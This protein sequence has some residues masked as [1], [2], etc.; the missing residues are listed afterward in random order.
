MILDKLLH[1]LSRFLTHEYQLWGKMS[2]YYQKSKDQSKGK[3]VPSDE[4]YPAFFQIDGNHPLKEKT[5]FSYVEYEAVRRHGGKIRYFDFDLAKELELIDRQHPEKLNPKLVSVLNDRFSFTIVNEYDV[6]NSTLAASRKRLPRKFMATRYLQLQNPNKKG[7]FSGD[8]RSVWNG[9]VRTEEGTLWDL[10]SCGT[11]ATC[12][13][14][15]TKI[16]GIFFQTGDPEISYGCG[17]A[18]LSEGIVDAVLS[19]YF[20][21]KSISCERVLCVIEYPDGYSIKV[22]A[23]RNLLRPSH[24]FGH[25]KQGQ[26]MRLKELLDYH[27]DREVQNKTPGIRDGKNRYELFLN[28]FAQRFGDVASQFEQEY[29]FCWLDWDG[30]NVMINGGLL[31][32]GSI[33]QFGVFFRDYKFDDGPLWSTSILEQKEKAEYTV[34]VMA[35]LI[36]F[37][38]SGNKKPLEKFKKCH[39]VKVFKE[40]FEHCSKKY[41]LRRLGLGLSNSEI[42][43]EKFASE[44]NVLRREFTYLERIISPNISLNTPDGKRHLVKY[45]MRKFTRWLSKLMSLQVSR[46]DIREVLEDCLTDQ[47]VEHGIVASGSEVRKALRVYKAFEKIAV[48]LSLDEVKLEQ[49]QRFWN[50][51]YRLTGDGACVVSEYLVKKSRQVK[52]NIIFKVIKSLHRVS[53]NQIDIDKLNFIDLSHEENKKVRSMLRHVRKIMNLY[54][55]SI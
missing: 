53:S 48:G 21:A 33:R 43:S 55:E 19:N 47:A 50:E 30:D 37:V 2:K 10:S 8:G 45:N 31:D 20:S 11:G 38:V 1:K 16:S 5:S 49:K 7:V 40:A 6:L 24:L 23:A 36:D 27:I 28:W 9:F 12:L 15:A 52:S 14:P 4:V 13:S 25:L 26:W 44:F 41:F 46:D 22:R 39:A 17:Y 32:F 54:S 3:Q 18:S 42:V 35:Q 51:P 34:K 29:L